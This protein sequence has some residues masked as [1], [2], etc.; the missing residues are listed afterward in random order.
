MYG[1]GN[2]L[3]SIPAPSLTEQQL[4]QGCGWG[5]EENWPHHLRRNTE[6][7]GLE[8]RKERMVSHIEWCWALRSLV[9]MDTVTREEFPPRLDHSL[10]S[11]FGH[12]FRVVLVM[13]SQTDL[14][15]SYT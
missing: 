7:A 6:Q 15:P 10:Q 3:I 8:G 5:R 14:A 12:S 4:V 9:P 11:C 13:L 1:S 2:E